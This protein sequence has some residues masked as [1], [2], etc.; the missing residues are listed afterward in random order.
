MIERVGEF[1][2][3]LEVAE[4]IIGSD[5]FEFRAFLKGSGS[6][7][8]VKHVVLCEEMIDVSR[9]RDRESMLEIVACNIDT[10]EASDFAFIDNFDFI[11]EFGNDRVAGGDRGAADEDVIYIDTH[12]DVFTDENAWV[13]FQSSESYTYNHL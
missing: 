1:L 4:F 6:R 10:E 5:H 2:A 12:D 7:F 8:G 9:L 11:R 13:S 3:E